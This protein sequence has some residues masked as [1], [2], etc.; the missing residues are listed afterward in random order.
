MAITTTFDPAAAVPAEDGT[1]VPARDDEERALVA[2]ARR[3][4]AEAF[5]TL[6]E[7]HH[8]RAIA[9]ARR[10]VRDAAE[11]EEVAQDAFLKAW[12]AR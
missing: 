9:L 2:R 8:A 4:D 10:V 1:L 12:E 6:V 11:A 3:G 5:R 7:A